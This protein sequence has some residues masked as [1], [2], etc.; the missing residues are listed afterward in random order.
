MQRQGCGFA[1]CCTRHLQGP[2][3]DFS[4]HERIR[5]AG[6]RVAS[7][8]VVLALTAG[9][10][11]D[12]DQAAAPPAPSSESSPTAAAPK[13][14]RTKLTVGTVTGHLPK[15]E[16]RRV[17]AAA[18]RVV[19]RWFE[20][21]YLGTTIRAAGSTTPSRATPGARAQAHADRALLT[22][23]DIGR[24]IDAATAQR[25]RA[26]RRSRSGT[27]GRPDRTFHARPGH[28]RR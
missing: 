28:R 3:K 27:G 8:I 15:K 16:Q 1:G 13:P 10:C 2:R 7:L 24:R 4:H 20:A 21:A 14:V 19:D 6:P 17:V 12:G 23:Q 22:N 5:A 25:R 26:G 9:G 18:G 11:R